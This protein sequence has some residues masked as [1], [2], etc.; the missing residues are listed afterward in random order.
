MHEKFSW[1]I[2]K[3][4]RAKEKVQLTAS[5]SPHLIH[6]AALSSHEVGKLA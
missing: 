4:L 2:L 3:V 6:K 1:F 5:L